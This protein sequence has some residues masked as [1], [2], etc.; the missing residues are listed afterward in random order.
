MAVDIFEQEGI[1]MQP[2]QSGGQPVDIFEKEGIQM[3]AQQSGAQQATQAIMQLAG[4]SPGEMAMR[5]LQAPSEIGGAAKQIFDPKRLSANI[6]AGLGKLGHA[7]L[8]MPSA[9]ANLLSK[10]GI[11]SKETAARVPRQKDYDFSSGA[12]VVGQKP[13]DALLQSLPGTA[14][15]IAAGEMGPAGRFLTPAKQTLSGAMMAGLQ[16]Q[17]PI[18]GGLT[19]TML[20]SLGA[21]APSA[22]RMARSPFVTVDDEVAANS[23][24]NKHDKIKDA[25]S[26]QFETISNEAQKRGIT[27]IPDVE[28]VVSASSPYL[29]KTNASKSMI[30]KA[31]SGDYD[32][33][34]KLQSD[35]RLR[36]EKRLSAD[37]AAERDAGEE[38]LDIRSDI[39]QKI[40]DH[41][42]NT[43]NDDLS[44]SLTDAMAKYKNFKDMYYSDNTI[45]KMVG[46]KREIPSNFFN[47]LKKRSV[48]MSRLKEAHPGAKSQLELYKA[49]QK[50]KSAPREA[51]YPLGTMAS[52]EA[53]KHYMGPG[54][55]QETGAEE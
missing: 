33:L 50:L 41:F 11:I 20:R 26:N 29:P 38:M 43:G 52:L 16:G 30:S 10:A 22:A 24:I 53:L 44:Q 54:G 1:Q 39:N 35:L 12:G 51:F 48:P 9:A 34:R 46:P 19:N 17:N 55:V 32:S 23:I 15:S 37:T 25:L 8:N 21:A 28:D 40:S 47:T 5:L 49:R 4:A 2:Q 45:A 42:G 3:P 13:G 18:T 14:M 7:E 31:K 6:L 36:G 27:Q